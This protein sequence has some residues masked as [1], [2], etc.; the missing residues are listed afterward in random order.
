VRDGAIAAAAKGAH[1]MRRIALTAVA[2][3]A[4]TA[5]SGG[6]VFAPANPA[7]VLSGQYAGSAA[8]NIYGSSTATTTLSE[9]GRT[10]YGTVTLI[11]TATSSSSTQ[12]VTFSIGSSYNLTGTITYGTCTFSSTGNYNT[13]TNVLSV[14]YA[15]QSGCAGETG[16]LTLT[17]ECTNPV[18]T[19]PQ[20]ARR[21]ESTLNAC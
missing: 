20:A 16:T 11:S 21:R 6:G 19:A 17:Q 3:F 9:A 15:S 4:L 7:D 13:T 2:I 12:A 14:S 1:M 8:D 10:L 5:C 18:M